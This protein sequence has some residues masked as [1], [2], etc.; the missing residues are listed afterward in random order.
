[1]HELSKPLIACAPRVDRNG[2]RQR[3]W[4]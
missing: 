4:T 3:Q 1:M 2:S